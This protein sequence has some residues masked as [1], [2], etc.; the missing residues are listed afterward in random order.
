MA[1]PLTKREG[2]PHSSFKRNQVAPIKAGRHGEPSPQ[3]V[4]R[5]LQ[6]KHWFTQWRRL[7]NLERA[8]KSTSAS[9]HLAHHIWSLWLSIRNA[10]GFGGGFAS[11]WSLRTIVR[12]NAPEFISTSVPQLPEVSLILLNF[13]AE[14]KA[15]DQ[16][17]HNAW[18]SRTKAKHAANPNAVFQ[19]VRDP[20]PVPV[21]VL[22]EHK[23]CQVLEVVDEGSVTVDHS[24]ELDP[25]LPL[26]CS[27][28]TLKAEIISE[29]QIRFQSLHDLAPGMT[30][31]QQRPIGSL[32]SMFDTFATEWSRRWD[33][34][35]AVTED[36]WNHINA[37]IDSQ[38]PRG[39]MECSPITLP[40]WDLV[41]RSKPSRSAVGMDGM[42]CCT[43]P[44]I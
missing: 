8:L 20:G 18:V 2:V 14:V 39:H 6:L 11:W 34:H 44:N 36:R 29:N 37:F 3:Y 42:I 25:S 35:R 28:V 10:P 9:P 27:G 5:S 4:G 32:S 24:D 30:I 31:V 21:E 19:A 1:F 26:I 38:V 16:Q 7:I 40:Q 43:C 15:L 17:L 22:L 23:T 41:I 12:P 13:A 33:K